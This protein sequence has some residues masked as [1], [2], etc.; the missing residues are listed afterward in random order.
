MTPP[1]PLTEKCP[2]CGNAVGAFR[3]ALS[4]REYEITGACQGCQDEIFAEP[5]HGPDDEG[6]PHCGSIVCYVARIPGPLRC[7][8]TGKVVQP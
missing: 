4:L 3:D 5:E 7:G 8:N 1:A 2:L 6:C